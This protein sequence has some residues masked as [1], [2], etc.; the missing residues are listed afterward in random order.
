LFVIKAADAFFSI[1]KRSGKKKTI[2][3]S[4]GSVKFRTLALVGRY[5]T[6]QFTMPFLYSPKCNRNFHMKLPQYTAQYH[7]KF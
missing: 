3:F 1:K 6:V 5:L 2:G 4:T 7:K